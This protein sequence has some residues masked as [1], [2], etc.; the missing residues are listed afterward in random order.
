M[1]SV[2]FWYNRKRALRRI[3]HD[4]T[5]AATLAEHGYAR[6]SLL[7][8]DDNNHA[9]SDPSG[10]SANTRGPGSANTRGPSTSS[11]TF[12][13]TGTAPVS[14]GYGLADSLGQTFNPQ[15]G[16]HAP[17]NIGDHGQTHD[18]QTG[19]QA[20]QQNVGGHGQTYDPNSNYQAP[21][22]GTGSHGQNYNPQTG[23]QAPQ[24]GAGSHGQTY[25]PQTSNQAPQQ[26]SG[27]HGQNTG[28]QA[29]QQSAN[30]GPS[31][32]SKFILPGSGVGWS[33]FGRGQEDNTG[34][35]EPLLGG[36]SGNDT[37]PEYASPLIPPRNPLRL[38]GGAED[39]SGGG[40]EYGD[41]DG[42][43]GGGGGYEDDDLE[44]DALRNLSLKVRSP[45]IVDLV[46]PLG[47][48]SS[49]LDSKQPR[50]PRIVS[51]RSG[52]T[53]CTMLD[54]SVDSIYP[55]PFP[56]TDLPFWGH[57]YLSAWMTID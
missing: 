23:N 49:V 48:S 25:N 55:E 5:V 3:D 14:T 35:N 51:A 1:V 29:P 30:P 13:G 52:E 37:P 11:M 24:Q 21:Q 45:G 22:Q 40:D 38:F 17:Q 9:V 33:L 16:F 47:C 10:S 44:Y 57:T 54:F 12:S 7:D 56:L 53:T 34:S 36:T 19:Y 18:P 32:I 15:A 41:G 50:I 8:G 26:G 27:S 6:Q 31:S 2:L 39:E 43:S 4:A 20:P 42:S 46:Y 28:Y